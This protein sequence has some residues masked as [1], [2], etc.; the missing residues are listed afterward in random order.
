MIEF[1]VGGTVPVYPTTNIKVI[2]VGGAGGNILRSLQGY[3]LDPL[4]LVAVNTDAQALQLLRDIHTIRIG[5]SGRGAGANPE[6]GKAAAEAD[7][8][9]IRDAVQGADVVFLIGGLGGGTGSGAL[10]VV[11]RLLKELDVL[12][13]CFVTKPFAF[14]GQRRMV[15]AQQAEDILQREV[16]T[17]IT[18]PNETLLSMASAETSFMDAFGMV[19][20]IIGESIRG[21]VD[22]IMKPGHINVDF[23]DIKTVMRGM[24]PALIGISRASGEDRAL[25]AAE[26]ALTS[27]FFELQSIKGARSALINVTG[28][29]TL[30]LYE[31]H[32][33]ASRITQELAHDA[34]IIVGSVVD[35][36]MGADVS[37][38]VIATGLATTHDARML[39][40]ESAGKRMEQTYQPGMHQHQQSAVSQEP[41]SSIPTRHP[42]QDIMPTLEKQLRE[43]YVAPQDDLDV[44][45]LLRKLMKEQQNLSS[46]SQ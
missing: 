29:H 24:G 21:I 28:N 46:N 27:A 40:R 42:L 6:V 3:I 26:S 18:V 12:T 11:A 37:V 22:L 1:E 10:P 33:A 32:A 35:E 2:G 39:H 23:S 36:T 14:E 31:V 7:L 38:T 13:I 45:T 5:T 17:L 15:V 16:D 19:N 9:M 4:S 41:V 8:Q 43:Q 30:T 20:E 44:P 25:H 34:L